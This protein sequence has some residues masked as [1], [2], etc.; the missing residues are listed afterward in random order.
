MGVLEEE[1][2]HLV[3]GIGSVRI[4]LGASTASARPGMPGAVDDPLLEDRLPAPVN[5]ESAALGTPAG[6]P[7]VLHRC[8]QVDHRGRLGLRDDLVAVARVYRGVPVPVEHDLRDHP[9]VI[10]Q[11]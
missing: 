2:Q 6:D 8:L 3:R 11:H 5:V 9:P 7:A 10:P 4:G 1:A